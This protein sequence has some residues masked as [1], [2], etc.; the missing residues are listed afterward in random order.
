MATQLTATVIEGQLRL[1]QPLDLP[2]DSKVIVTVESQSE[3]REK[4]LK[5]L[6]EWR[7]FT[8]KHPINSGGVRFTREELHE[9]R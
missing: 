8:E 7:K 4:Y 9:R 3:W 5:G 1:D 6:E 2:N